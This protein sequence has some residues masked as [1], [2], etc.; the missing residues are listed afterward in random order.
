[1]LNQVPRWRPSWMMDQLQSYNTWSVLH[2]ERNIHAMLG[3]IPFSGSLKEV[4][5]MH[6]P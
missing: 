4:I 2:K 6:F 5:C 1:M 3:F